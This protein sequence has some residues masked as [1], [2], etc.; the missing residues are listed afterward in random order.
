M[1]DIKHLFDERLK[2]L[3][4]A[5]QIVDAALSEE[6][7]LSEEE[8]ANV[9]RAAADATRLAAAIELAE[10]RDAAEKAAAEYIE[11]V[12]GAPMPPDEKRSDWAAVADMLRS[13]A[14]GN[15]TLPGLPQIRGRY[16]LPWEQRADT[17]LVTGD[18]SSTYSGYLV[19][20]P[21]SSQVEEMAYKVSA[22][23]QAGCD[24]IVTAG[25][26]T[27]NLPKVT[28]LP[29]LAIGTEGSAPSDSSQPV[30]GR[31]Q[32]AAYRVGGYTVI[33]LEELASS[34]VD[35]A[36]YIQRILVQSLGQK[37]ASYLAV[38]TGSGQP[39][40]LFVGAATGKTAANVNTFTADEVVQAF[41]ALGAEYWPGAAA[42]VSQAGFGLLL[43]LRDLE[44][45]PLFMPSYAAGAP[46][47]LLGLPC[48]VDAQGPALTTGKKPVVF[49]QPAHY[50]VRLGMG[51]GV[52][53]EVSD[54][55][56]FAA[57]NR[58]VRIAQWVDGQIGVAAAFSAL[59]LA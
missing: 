26:N 50:H 10:Q 25:I 28:T 7:E 34:E 23:L 40:G 32:L 18:T 24:V 38:G 46:D 19:P 12:G 52:A 44:D 1:S 9:D 3:S 4:A 15:G 31:T 37:V 49:G 59:T 58:V 35:L 13:G 56:E 39:Q 8:Q 17:P 14:T 30:F 11:R 20:S 22:P 21:V 47:R 43:T 55:A 16:V 5:Q 27:L 57:F 36:S 29:T 54:E 33:S 45:R 2:A 42:F 41:T 48:Y 6:R 51:G 53:Y